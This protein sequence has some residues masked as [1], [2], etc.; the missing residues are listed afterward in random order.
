MRFAPVVVVMLVA[1]NPF[2]EGTATGTVESK[3][4]MGTWTFASGACQSGE[5]ESYYGAIAFGPEGS[6]IA[7]KLVK[8]GV[9]GWTAVVNRADTCKAG[10]EKSDCK[11]IKLSDKDCTKLAVDIRTTNTTINDIK[12]VEG[13]LELDCASGTDSIKGRLVFDYCH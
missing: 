7:I 12:V 2:K 10:V 13:T 1:C 8:D 6:G 9:S 11:A 4:A 3:G 5:R